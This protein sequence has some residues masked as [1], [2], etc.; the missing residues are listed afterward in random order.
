MMATVHAVSN[1]NKYATIYKP[2]EESS[3]SLLD[4]D[5]LRMLGTKLLEEGLSNML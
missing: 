5:S 1:D 4:E 3:L 2:K